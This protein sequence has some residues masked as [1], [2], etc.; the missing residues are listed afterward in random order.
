M[1][2]KNEIK[3]TEYE[4]QIKQLK[5]KTSE[6]QK[7]TRDLLNERNKLMVG[8]LGDLKNKCFKRI[9]GYACVMKVLGRD[10][11]GDL[12]YLLF[13]EK[14]WSCENNQFV[15]RQGYINC[16]PEANWLEEFEE[17]SQKEF[18]AFIAKTV[19]EYSYKKD[20]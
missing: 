2:V 20:W 10:D 15:L 3:L 19:E 13:E 4:T 8:Q 11:E 16:F 7:Q 5:E 1:S 9:K 14:D 6:I 17:I 18:V 12:R